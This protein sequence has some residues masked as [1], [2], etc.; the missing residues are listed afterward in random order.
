[1]SDTFD[2]SAYLA[3]NPDVA[4]AVRAG[5]IPSGFEHYRQWGRHERRLMRPR[6]LLTRPIFERLAYRPLEAVPSAALRERVSG[7]SSAE[8]FESIGRTI[9]TDLLD[10]KVLHQIALP[11][12]ARVLDFGCG[13]GRVLRHLAPQCIGKF[14]GVD[15]DA[16]AIA[17]C[18]A[19][20]SSG[21]SH[22][23]E[24]PPLPFDDEQFDLIYS[25]SVFTHL[26]EEMQIAW[27]TELRRIAKPEAWLL[28]SVHAPELMPRDAAALDQMAEHGFVYLRGA[29]TEGLPDFY[30]VAYHAETYI[31]RVWGELFQIEAVRPQ[32]V[33]NHQ[34]LV[35]ARPR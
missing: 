22:N 4:E 8:T 18:K 23:A 11:S 5:T 15:I 19:N 21:F 13:C 1:M 12:E 34:D 6:Q 27:L 2:E 28:L 17:W 25:V 31:R 16:E 30:R 10:A 33:N 7:S 9:A 26:P 29:P 20:L 32:W 24:W 3:A 14:D 35:V